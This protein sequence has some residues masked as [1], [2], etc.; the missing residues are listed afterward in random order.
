MLQGHLTAKNKRRK[1]KRTSRAKIYLR[2]EWSWEEQGATAD[3]QQHY[4]HYAHMLHNTDYWHAISQRWRD[5]DVWR[6][7][8]IRTAWAS[9]CERGGET[10]NR[11]PR[12]HIRLTTNSVIV[13][14]FFPLVVVLLLIK[15]LITK[16]DEIPRNG[17]HRSVRQSSCCKK[18]PVFAGFYSHRPSSACVSSR[19]PWRPPGP[20]SRRAAP[21]SGRWPSGRCPLGRRRRRSCCSSAAPRCRAA[22]GPCFSPW[23][24]AGGD[25][26]A[27]ALA[28]STWTS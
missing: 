18:A 8:R 23:S 15:T 1:K 21:P 3:K 7:G 26:S 14:F 4:W 17:R 22:C 16:Y 12:Q 13:T 11:N 6:R 9:S 24:P 28:F 27:L 20:W 2:R 10:K 19:P 25:A 5:D